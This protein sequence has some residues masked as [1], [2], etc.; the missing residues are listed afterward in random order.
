MEMSMFRMTVS[1][2]RYAI[3]TLAGIGF[4]VSLN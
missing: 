3:S 2:L 1:Y 4:G